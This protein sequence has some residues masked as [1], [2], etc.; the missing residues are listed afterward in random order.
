[1]R[2]PAK[3]AIGVSVGSAADREGMTGMT[4]LRLQPVNAALVQGEM[5]AELEAW[6]EETRDTARRLR[7]FSPEIAATIANLANDVEA[8]L[9]AFPPP[10]RP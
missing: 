4:S 10:D 9:Q 8:G 5:R 7:V 2:A 3:L 6:I 1:M